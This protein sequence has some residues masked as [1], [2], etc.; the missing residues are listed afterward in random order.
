[1]KAL[2]VL[3]PLVLAGAVVL[4]AVS[5]VT[6]RAGAAAR[7]VALERL[8]LELVER[9]VVARG[10]P[11]PAGAEEAAA[12]VRWWF[13]GL[14]RL[15]GG[16]PGRG[17]GNDS[18]K[19]SPDDGWRGY[20]EERLAALRAGYAPLAGGV[21]Q[22][23]RLDLLSVSPAQH[24]D[25]GQRMLR[26]DFALWGAPRR[27]EPEGPA[28][29]S[30][31]GKALRVIVP[32]AF[33]QLTFRFLTAGGKGYGEMAGQGEPYRLLKD[34]ERFSE[35]LP[36]GVALGTWWLEPF[37]REAARV[38]V[39]VAAQVQGTSSA[40]LTPAFRFELAV[41]E[42]WQLR[43]GEAFEAEAREAPPEPSPG[44]QP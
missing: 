43:P 5:L 32:V 28:Q 23:I 34:P 1:M 39:T 41:P 37:P 6:R 4:L 33:R 27:L 15:G 31:G 44:K 13:E 12:L 19:S 14:D 36:P 3:V 42:A 22:G 20:A 9:S 26:V 38:E 25:S 29:G 21:D 40:S 7:A 18:R 16:A 30:D 24:P 35:A 8:R 10:A 2:R 11:G 17:G